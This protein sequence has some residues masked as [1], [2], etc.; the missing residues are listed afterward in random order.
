M[1]FPWLFLYGDP[2]YRSVRPQIAIQSPI[3]LDG[4]FGLHPSL[5]PLKPL[6]NAGHLAI[7]HAVGS[8]DNTRSHFDAQDFMESGA[9]GN[10]GIGDGWLNRYLQTQPDRNATPARAVAFSPNMPRTLM[11]PAPAV[12]M[13]RIN[14]FGVRAGTASDTVESAFEAMYGHEATGKE[15][16]K[17]VNLLKQ[18]NPSSTRLKTARCIHPLHMDRHCCRLHN[19]SR[20]TSDSKSLLRTSADGTRMRTRAT[21]A[22]NFPT[23]CVNSAKVSRRFLYRDLGDRM[24]NIVV[25]TM[26]GVRS[27]CPSKRIGRNRSRSCQRHVRIRWPHQRWQG[28][29]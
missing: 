27:S 19:S 12:A 4:F 21:N 23:D 7:V 8:P 18:A 26:T 5:D 2:Y 6:Y 1:E 11:G 15:T 24:E 14:E 17:A 16:F 3:D 22:D 28:L 9:P 29:R 10:K 13:T 20:R 25:L